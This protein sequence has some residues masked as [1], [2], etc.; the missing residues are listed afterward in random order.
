VTET[1]TSLLR[2]RLDAYSVV[3]PPPEPPVAHRVYYAFFDAESSLLASTYLDGTW[4][5]DRAELSEPFAIDCLVLTDSADRVGRGSLLGSVLAGDVR[6]G[7]RVWDVESETVYSY[8]PEPG[9]VVSPPGIADGWIYWAQ[10]PTGPFTAPATIELW[11]A[12]ADLTAVEIFAS[13]TVDEPGFLDAEWDQETYLLLAPASAT[14]LANWSTTDL[15]GVVACRFPLDG[16]TTPTSAL[17]EAETGIDNGLAVMGGSIKATSQGGP[18][19]DRREDLLTATYE[20]LWPTTGS[21]ALISWFHAS[22]SESRSDASLYGTAAG[23]PVLLRSP[24]SGLFGDAPETSFLVEEHP[25][26]GE[27]PRHFFIGD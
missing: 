25:T 9:P 24:V 21:W 11:R 4:Q 27:Y 6:T 22:I 26:V 17:L 8:D 16:E 15:A 10:H 14:V 18:G 1:T 2:R 19:L 12:R 13:A 20:P 5:A 23:G 3:L 7:I